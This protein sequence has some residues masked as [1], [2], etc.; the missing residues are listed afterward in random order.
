[1]S[2]YGRYSDGHHVNWEVRPDL[3][4]PRNLHNE[5]RYGACLGEQVVRGAR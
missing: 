2:G 1:M 4:D 5:T 3:G